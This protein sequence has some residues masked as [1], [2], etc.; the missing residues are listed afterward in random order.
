MSEE[1]TG[2][3]T[4]HRHLEEARNQVLE[5]LARQ[6]VESDLTHRS[7]QRSHDVV[8]QLMERQH[9]AALEQL[10][11]RLHP[12]DIAFVLENLPADARDQAW[13]RVR[14][15]L[16]GAVLLETSD[17]VRRALIRDLG[18]E[19]IAT[20]V[21]ALAT[22]DIADLLSSLS[23]E[24]R[25]QVIE[26]LDQ[27][28]RAEVRTLLAF[29]PESVGARMDLDVVSVHQDTTI[30]SVQRLLRRRKELPAHTNEIFVVDGR[31]RPR[32]LLPLERLLLGD[33]QA[34]VADEMRTDPVYFCTDDPMRDAVSAFEKYDLVSAPVVNLHDEIVGRLTVDAV[35]DEIALRSQSDQLRQ[36][37][38][39]SED[40]DLAAPVGQSARRRWPWLAINLCTALLASR[41]IGAFEPVI[42]KLVALAALMPIVAS[43]GGN[44]GNQSVALMLQSLSQAPLSGQDLRRFLGRE[45]AIAALNGTVWGVV[46]AGVALILYQ[47]PALACV[48]GVALLANLIVAA[49]IGVLTPALLRRADR[50][51][52]MGSS[53]ILTA[54]TD[55][56]GF[57][58]FLGLAALFLT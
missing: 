22:E 1:R 27:A 7:Q 58:I 50:D 49:A 5:L 26:R 51:P 19:E 16:R 56:L 48:L 53:I 25:V 9:R 36:V 45:L 8:I 28:D 20:L 47:D 43:I 35:V 21:C 11:A 10:L 46:V 17:A 2:E 37:G 13:M 38:L 44:A 41:V 34:R 39:S 3:R 32:G 14:A 30:E 33:P 24:T 6:A 29:P 40:E 31:N 42:D 4:H 15:E 54:A 52:A 57:L 23:E 18:C 12:A 55:S